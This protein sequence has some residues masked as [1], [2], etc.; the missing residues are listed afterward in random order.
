MRK[1]DLRMNEEYKYNVIKR[2]VDSNGNKLRASLQLKCSLR[3]VNRLIIKYKEQGKTAFIHGNRNRKPSTTY[4]GEFK[5]M[6]QS[7][8][9]DIYFDCNIQHFSELIEMNHDYNISQRTLINWLKEI[10]VL[11]PKARRFTK[12]ELRKKLK[13]QLRGSNKKDAIK[14]ENSIRQLDYSEIHPRHPRCAYFG[15]LLQMDASEHHWFGDDVPKAHLHAAIDDST[16]TIV[17]AYFDTQEKLHGYYKVLSSVL[18]TYGAPAKIQTDNRMIFTNNK[19][20]PSSVEN[21]RVNFAYACDRLGIALDTTSVPEANG[22]IERLFQTLQSRLIPELR[23]AN[24]KT[25]EEANMFLKRYIKQFNKRFALLIDTNKNVFTEQINEST[26][27]ET[28][29]VIE[30]RIIDKGHSIKYKNELY[31]P[32]DAY[33][34]HVHLMR[35]T[36]CDVIK[37]LDDTLYLCT[38]DELFL[39]EL[40]PIRHDKS[41]EFDEIVEVKKKKQYIPPLTHPW[42]QGSYENYLLKQA[43]QSRAHI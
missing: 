40:I 24:V 28:L 4:T 19:K 33:G 9:T 11:S 38:K 31:I 27:N 18:S 20:E 30:T 3:T 7:L 42:R 34:K 23:L 6:I 10:D 36:K 25:I 13:Q 26:I 8:Y 32:T 22:R 41:P 14:I 35:H 37:A 43:P 15:E 21:S 12:R 2:L 5:E 17:G 29:A 1:V 16:G 39:L